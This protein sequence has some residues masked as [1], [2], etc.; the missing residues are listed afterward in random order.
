MTTY[1]IES[2]EKLIKYCNDRMAQVE[3]HSEAWY[4]LRLA[5]DIRIQRLDKMKGNN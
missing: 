1:E 5:R 4:D 3:L 2:L